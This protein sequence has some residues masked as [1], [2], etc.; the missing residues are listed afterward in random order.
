MI[1]KQKIHTADYMWER[2]QHY[3]PKAQE[4]D[5]YMVITSFSGHMSIS[6]RFYKDNIEPSLLLYAEKTS[7]D[8]YND[9]V[10]LIWDLA[11]NEPVYEMSRKHEAT[12]KFLPISDT[13]CAQIIADEQIKQ[14]R[15]RAKIVAE[16]EK[17]NN[18]KQANA[19]KLDTAE[20]AYSDYV[21]DCCEKK[22]IPL[23]FAQ[24]L[25]T[26]PPLGVPLDY[27]G[28]DVGVHLKNRLNN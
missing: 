7:T 11:N 19:L 15:E 4:H 18:E 14:A 9:D 13:Q 21:K 23:I 20:K 25:E 10:L 22:E 2:I 16:N 17:R 1:Q 5:R 12:N 3:L 27:D 24:F 26:Y 28:K 6:T 8:G